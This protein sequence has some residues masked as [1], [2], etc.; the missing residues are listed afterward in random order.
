MWQQGFHLF[1]FVG[2]G[3]RSD[4]AGDRQ[5]TEHIVNRGHQTLRIMALAG[6]VEPTIRIKCLA[7]GLGSGQMVF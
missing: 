7:Q 6:V 2:L 3:H 5:S 1:A 4:G